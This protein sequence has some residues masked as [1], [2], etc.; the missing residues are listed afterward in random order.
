MKAIACTKYGPPEILKMM[1]VE[2]YFLK[3]NEILIQVNA[4]TVPMG[5]TKI[6]RFE[7]GLGPVKDF[8]QA[9][10]ANDNWFQ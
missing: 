1:E 4:T 6:R 2:K 8:F 3:N 5:D 10:D 9:S 7:P